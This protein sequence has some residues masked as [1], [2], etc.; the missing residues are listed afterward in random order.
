MVF[1]CIARNANLWLCSRILWT[2][3]DSR[4]SPRGLV[5][6]KDYSIF[7]AAR[8]NLVLV[9]ASP[10]HHK[11]VQIACFLMNLNKIPCQHNLCNSQLQCFPLIIFACNSFLAVQQNLLYSLATHEGFL[12]CLQWPNCMVFLWELSNLMIACWAFH[13][14]LTTMING[15]W[16]FAPHAVDVGVI[17]YIAFLKK[18]ICTRGL[19]CKRCCSS[20]VMFCHDKTVILDG[21]W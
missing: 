4:S 3:Q 2:L 12:Q 13:L 19:A 18:W 10:M 15:Q 6:L 9:C 17:V 5:L 7:A 8:K 21:L 1:E 16:F 20:C 11:L 14:K